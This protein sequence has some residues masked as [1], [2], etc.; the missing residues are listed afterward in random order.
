[1]TFNARAPDYLPD[2]AFHWDFGDGNEAEGRKVAHD[3]QAYGTGTR[4][5]VIR[6][7]VK[8]EQERCDFMASQIIQV[9]EIP[10]A[11]FEGL[12]GND[13]LP[14]THCGQLP[15]TVIIRPFSQTAKTNAQ[16]TVD[17]ETVR[18]SKPI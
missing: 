4:S 6:L 12:P 16:Y 7:S 2:V 9:K 18:Q 10:H 17:W 3:F 1:M 13:F 14:F 5:F 11:A 15:D 8:D